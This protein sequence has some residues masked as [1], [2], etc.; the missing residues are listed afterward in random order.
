MR[1][2]GGIIPPQ[3]VR[4]CYT[5]ARCH[6]LI[7]QAEPQNDRRVPVV[8]SCKVTCS[9]C[10]F[11]RRKRSWRLSPACPLSPWSFRLPRKPVCRL[12]WIRCF[13]CSLLWGI[14]PCSDFC[15]SRVV[16][17]SVRGFIH[18]LRG[19]SPR[20]PF[21]GVLYPHTPMLFIIRS[22]PSVAGAAAALGAILYKSK[23]SRGIMPLAGSRG[24][25][26][27]TLPPGCRAAP[28]QKAK[29]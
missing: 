27:C 15:L 29:S 21:V 1:G 14:A 3:G 12:L 22:A 13:P 23:G 16:C 4:G 20:T 9:F 6:S 17:R 8:L 26:P 19:Y 18:R 24:R 11:W 2:C 7:K 5:L 28:L 10:S 25:A